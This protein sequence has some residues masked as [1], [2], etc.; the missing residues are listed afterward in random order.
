VEG[1]KEA[2]REGRELPY[3][4]EASS[5]MFIGLQCTTKIHQLVQKFVRRRDT[6][7]AYHKRFKAL[8]RK[9]KEIM[10][11]RVYRSRKTLVLLTMVVYP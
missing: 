9:H 10:R 2:R 3:K 6:L 1:K 5:G 8:L 7:R 4:G 11:E